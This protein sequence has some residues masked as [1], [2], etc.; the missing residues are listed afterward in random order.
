MQHGQQFDPTD[1]RNY[2]R[3]GEAF[4]QGET[5]SGLPFD[6]AIDLVEELKTWVPAGM[7]MAQMAMRWILDHEAVS[8]I[9]T[10]ASRP[11]QVLDNAAVSGLEPLSPELHRKLADFY[12]EKVEPK[13]C[14]PI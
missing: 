8:T 13:I 6:L 1:H 10:G 5:F 7:S 12:R 9:I 2:N 3:H 14:V 11:Q 4:S